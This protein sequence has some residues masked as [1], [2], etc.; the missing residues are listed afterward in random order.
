MLGELVHTDGQEGL[1]G[2]H[3]VVMKRV[4]QLESGVTKAKRTIVDLE[5]QL[6]VGC[7]CV[8]VCECVCGVVARST[9]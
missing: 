7:A 3:D 5:A 9:H 1:G 4:R 8:R 2:V 6:E